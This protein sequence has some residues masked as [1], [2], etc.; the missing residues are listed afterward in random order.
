MMNAP[1]AINHDQRNIEAGQ[2][3]ARLAHVLHRVPI[4]TPMLCRVRQGEKLVQWDEH[5]MR[6]GSQH[7]ILLPAG[8]ELG[9]ANYPGAQ[10]AYIADVITLT[11]ELLRNFRQHHGTTIDAHAKSFTDLCV[12]LDRHAEIAWENLLNSIAS[13]AP[14]SMRIHYAEGVLLALSLTGSAEPL[15]TD[16]RDPLGARIQQLLM[17]DLAADWTVSVVAERLHLGAST[18][19]RQLA[20]EGSSFSQILEQ[21]RLGLALQW[22]QTSDRPIGEIAEASGYAS[23]SRFAIRFR[24]HYGLSP[25]ELR[26][27]I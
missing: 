23:A 6:V 8:R 12:P 4:F 1:V 16:R 19:R 3:Q 20:N 27:A 22:I 7:L 18:L 24:R 14:Q 17:L 9:I 10:G 11:P 26:A 13:D 25:R 15:L 2:I 5:S 21:V